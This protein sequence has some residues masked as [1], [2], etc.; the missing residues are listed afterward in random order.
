MSDL[1]DRAMAIEVVEKM[2]DVFFDRKVILAKVIDQLKDM[3][4][5]EPR[6][7]CEGCKY[8]SLSWDEEPCDTCRL[9]TDH[10]EERG[11]EE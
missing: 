5:A 1:I 6:R 4:S 10:Y 3:P 8:S 11:E 9:E 7:G 2:M